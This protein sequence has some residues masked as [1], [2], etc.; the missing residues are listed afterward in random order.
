MIPI[1]YARTWLRGLSACLLIAGCCGLARA[2]TGAAKP[3]VAKPSVAEPSASMLRMARQVEERVS[4]L[5]GLK[6]LRPTRFALTDKAAVRA[7]L[8][9]LVAE[10][11][12]PGELA[13]EGLAMR[14]LGLLPAGLDYETAML[15]LYEEQVGGYYDPKRE[16]FYL[17]DWLAPSSQE[18]IIAHE[19]THVLQDQHFNL[20]NFMKRL[21]GRSDAMLARAALVEGGATLVMTLDQVRY[22][23]A[24]PDLAGVDLE[25]SFGKVMMNLSAS[26]YPKFAASPEALKSLLMFPYLYGQRFVARGRDLGGWGRIDKVYGQVPVSSEQILHP[27]KYFDKLDAPTLVDMSW[28]KS[29]MAEGSAWVQVYA[30]V[31]GE[32]MWRLVLGGLDDG[33]DRRRAAAGWDGDGLRVWRRASDGAL[34][35]LALTVWDSESDAVEFAGALAKTVAGRWPGAKRQAIDDLPRMRWKTTDGRQVL[36]QRF[37]DRVL[38]IE[39]LP[40]ADCDRLLRVFGS[41][42]K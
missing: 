37:G 40:S 22:A 19:L 30:D 1:I 21:K 12:G 11:Y 2:Q 9:E 36:L 4:R 13:R 7:Y 29:A 14:A 6:V 3:R 24:E 23:G 34:A 35:W 5:R 17:A 20:D 38:V 8:K 32:F 10:Q 25:G 16:I 27:E 15:G 18:G 42:G 33:D 39:G 31:L 41:S 28:Q 26:Q